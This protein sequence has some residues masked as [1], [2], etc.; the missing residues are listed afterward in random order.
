[1]EINVPTP[2]D[3]NRQITEAIAASAIGE[4]LHKIVDAEVKKLG[5][6]FN[7]P[8]QGV[9]ENYIRSEIAA[10]L[11]SEYRDMIREK[12]KER[13]SDERVDTLLADAFKQRNW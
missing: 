9:V 4:Q 13:L 10:I 2:E 11:A 1:M 3:I 6:T 5:Q 12:I 7:N 8:L